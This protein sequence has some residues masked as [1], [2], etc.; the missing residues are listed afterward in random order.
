MIRAVRRA[1]EP[2][3]HGSPIRPLR[4][5]AFPLPSVIPPHHDLQVVCLKGLNIGLEVKYSPE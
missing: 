4:P 3:H 1:R 2:L 5:R